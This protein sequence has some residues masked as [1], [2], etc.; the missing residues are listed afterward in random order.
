MLLCI[1]ACLRACVPAFADG[2]VYSKGMTAAELVEP[3]EASFE[4]CPALPPYH[5]PTPLQ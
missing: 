2:T 5:P 4:H 3:W 1:H